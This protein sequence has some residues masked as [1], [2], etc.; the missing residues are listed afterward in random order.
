MEMEQVHAGRD[1]IVREL[2]LVL[3]LVGPDAF[4][5]DRA[6]DVDPLPAPCAIGV[7]PGEPARLKDAPRIGLSRALTASQRAARMAPR[8]TRR[9]P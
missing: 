5:A 7:A 2:H 3:H 8:G 4:P 6:G 1:A 9:Y